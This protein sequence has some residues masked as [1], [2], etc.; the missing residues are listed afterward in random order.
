MTS[1]ADIQFP[2]TPADG[3]LHQEAGRHFMYVGE[4]VEHPDQPGRK[5]GYWLHVCP[6]CQW[7]AFGHIDPCVVA[8]FDEAMDDLDR[9]AAEQVELYGEPSDEWD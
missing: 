4:G 5:G 2:A 7:G 9:L 6:V 1:I 8:D 3:A